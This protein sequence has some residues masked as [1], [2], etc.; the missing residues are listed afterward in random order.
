MS[1]FK[2]YDKDLFFVS[3]KAKKINNIGSVVYYFVRL[4]Q[5]SMRPIEV[6][7]IKIG[8]NLE[9]FSPQ[10]SQMKL[11]ED[12]KRAYYLNS[13]AFDK[14][15]VSSFIDTIENKEVKNNS[16]EVFKDVFG[17]KID[18]DVKGLEFDRVIYTEGF[19]INDTD[20]VADGYVYVFSDIAT[21]RAKFGFFAGNVR[22]MRYD[23]YV[24]KLNEFGASNILNSI[25]ITQKNK[26][27]TITN[28]TPF[29]VEITPYMNSYEVES[30]LYGEKIY[31]RKKTLL[32]TITLKP[33]ASFTL[34]SERSQKELTYNL[35]NNVIKNSY[36]NEPF[37]NKDELYIS[38]KDL[39][40]RRPYE[41]ELKRV[42]L[43]PNISEDIEEFF[44]VS[45]FVALSKLDEATF[46]ILHK[47]NPSSVTINSDIASISF[48]IQELS[49][50]ATPKGLKEKLIKSLA[51]TLSFVI[52]N[53]QY[54]FNYT[55]KD[56]EIIITEI[57][58]KNAFNNITS[59]YMPSVIIKA[60]ILNDYSSFQ[61]QNTKIKIDPVV[62]SVAHQDLPYLLK[63]DMFK[64]NLFFVSLEDVSDMVLRKPY[65]QYIFK[66]YVK[67]L[68][69]VVE[70]FIQKRKR[71]IGSYKFINIPLEV[72]T[73]YLSEVGPS[74]SVWNVGSKEHND[75]AY[76]VKHHL[77]DL[78]YEIALEEALKRLK[79][80]IYFFQEKK[81][82][83]SSVVF[84][85]SLDKEWY[86]IGSNWYKKDEIEN[87]KITT[88]L[89]D[90]IKEYGLDVKDKFM[91]EK[92]SFFG[93]DNSTA[94]MVS[95]AKA[96]AVALKT[97]EPI[98]Y[99]LFSQNP[100]LTFIMR[101]SLGAE[102][103][104][105]HF[106]D[107]VKN[108]QEFTDRYTEKELLNKY[109]FPN[110]F[111]KSLNK[112]FTPSLFS[113]RREL[114][115]KRLIQNNALD[116]LDNIIKLRINSS[117]FLAFD[118]ETLLELSDV[119]KVSGYTILGIEDKKYSLNSIVEFSLQVPQNKIIN[120]Y[121]YDLGLEIYINKELRFGLYY[122]IFTK[123]TYMY[124]AD[125]VIVKDYAFMIALLDTMLHYNIDDIRGY[126][127]KELGVYQPNVDELDNKYLYLPV[128]RAIESNYNLVAISINYISK[129]FFID[130]IEKHSA[131]FSYDL[132]LGYK[133]R[134][135]AYIDKD[136]LILEKDN[137]SVE[138]PLIT[139]ENMPYSSMEYFG[140][141]I[142]PYRLY[143]F[144]DSEDIE[145][146]SVFVEIEYNGKSLY[147]HIDFAKAKWIEI[148]DL[149][150]ML[151][152]DKRGLLYL[153]NVGNKIT[154]FN[155][156]L[157]IDEIF[158]KKSKEL[159]FKVSVIN[160]QGGKV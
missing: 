135:R 12:S 79:K 62:Y 50:I 114:E 104:F 66:T 121:L 2:I 70:E 156:L 124:C 5:T 43:E 136:N 138:I 123:K 111:D 154:D 92:K 120:G 4:T 126:Q 16:L 95:Y 39:I 134:A 38:Q 151:G 80:T 88:Y 159:D 112:K 87:P 97:S 148:D 96:L 34:H 140:F 60:S 119:F 26:E 76:N 150:I 19:K 6:V 51:Q 144:L 72:S 93:Y 77:A 44:V 91:Y 8:N 41:F 73:A 158:E 53:Q 81:E 103:T 1:E 147:Q 155:E 115:L 30:R 139:L 113:K 33:Y 90:K 13:I 58:F 23:E 74:S 32:E 106:E 61:E 130:L 35:L 98:P 31:K 47:S 108:I 102:V 25:V 3:K 110:I 83:L 14:E 86:F 82:V 29:Y 68:D 65:H 24:N 128:K 127:F 152:L 10:L 160:V 54:Y 153:R 141:L 22:N 40:Q 42:G 125:E 56:S 101:A 46:N 100:A 67:E 129:S 146:K 157:T 78:G 27:T 28:N 109:V 55:L 145:L 63:S 99:E 132:G 117:V 49:Y 17:V 21:K 142:K 20:L 37:S 116:V 89:N 131:S 64:S 137:S 45:S 7:A 48:N 9:F 149:R 105:P 84:G 75:F 94:E 69:D 36:V 122:S 18:G 52:D 59:E 57:A 71:A 143:R 107:L 85:V 118:N 133:V 15:A 11:G